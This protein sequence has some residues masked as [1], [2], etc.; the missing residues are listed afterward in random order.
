MKTDEKV[1]ISLTDRVKSGDESAFGELSELFAPLIGAKISEYADVLER[2]EI[3]QIADIALFKAA[4]AYDVNKSNGE[5]TFG[6]YAKICI[7]NQLLSELRKQKP[8]V[9]ALDEM[10]DIGVA[11]HEEAVVDRQ[12]FSSKLK[13]KK[14]ELTEYEK[15]VLSLYLD[16]CSY[17]E[18]SSKLGK[19]FK[20]VANAVVRIKAKLRD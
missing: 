1:I 20:S 3:K 12:Y 2:E 7:N 15:S 18:I 19:D 16:G 8:A 6:L 17:A 4:M 10:L 11:S 13:R 9:S 14:S 5:V